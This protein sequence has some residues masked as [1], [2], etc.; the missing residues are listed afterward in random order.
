MKNYLSH[1][2]WKIYTAGKKKFHHRWWYSNLL[3]ELISFD[4]IVGHGCLCLNLLSELISL[5]IVILVMVV[6]HPVRG[7]WI[8]GEMMLHQLLWHGQR[9]INKESC[10]I[11]I[12]C[13]STWTRVEGGPQAVPVTCTCTWEQIREAFILE[14]RFHT[15]IFWLALAHEGK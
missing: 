3:S 13:F 6:F 9:R 5:V 7:D 11:G 12:C 10:S 15:F 1:S 2:F 8:D 4:S 14:T